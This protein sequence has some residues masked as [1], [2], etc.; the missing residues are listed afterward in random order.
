MI[1][2]FKCRE[3]EKIFNLKFSRKL[4]E[5]IQQ[6]ALRKHKY[7][8]AAASLEDLKVPP[9]NQFEALKGDR[10]GQYSIRINGQW[11]ICFKWL[12]GNASDVEIVDYH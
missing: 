9:D 10:K 1:N 3:T 12:D 11:K 6:V 4:P 5:S 8:Y 7:L 2:S